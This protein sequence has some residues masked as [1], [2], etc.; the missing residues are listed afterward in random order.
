MLLEP[1]PSESGR[2]RGRRAC[3]PARRTRSGPHRRRRSR[4]RPT[5]RAAKS[6]APRRRDPILLEL[7]NLRGVGE[8]VPQHLLADGL[9]HHVGLE[10]VRL[11]RPT[12]VDSNS[13]PRTRPLSRAACVALP[14]CAAT[15]RV[16]ART[17]ARSG[18]RSCSPG[19]GGRPWSL[20]R[21]AE[22]LA[23]HRDV[24][25][26]HAAADHDDAAARR[27]AMPCQAPGAASRCSRPRSRRL[28]AARRRA[29]GR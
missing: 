3:R 10:R 24:D 22:R 16:S 29:R 15:R 20:L 7:E 21:C 23:L 18:W 11:S 9:E 25:G 12:C 13:T 27:A 26:G 6:A 1:C 28:R 8:L 4:R 2:W 5:R 17:P 14:R 19:R